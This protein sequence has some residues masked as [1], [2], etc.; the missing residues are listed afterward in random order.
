MIKIATVDEWWSLTRQFPE[1]RRTSDA[2]LKDYGYMCLRKFLIDHPVRRVLEFGHGMNPYLLQLIQDS[3]QAWGVD[4]WQGLHYFP[5]RD[6]WVRDYTA[7]VVAACPRARLVRG[8]LAEPSTVHLPPGTFDMI[9]S[10]SVLEEISVAQAVPIMQHAYRLLRPGGFFVNT[11][12]ICMNRETAE[13][14]RWY[15]Q[16]HHSAGLK[17][18][19][20]PLDIRLD[21]TLLENPTTVMHLYQQSDGEQR[22]FRGHWGTVFSVAVKPEA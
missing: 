16:A 19:L 15:V 2:A 17:L 13:Q 14:I 12:D 20:P 9:C 1:L 22:W 18:D 21:N 7:S 6:E 5:P 8:L 3:H 10:V 11:R 4:D